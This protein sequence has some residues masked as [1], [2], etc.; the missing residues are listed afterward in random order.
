MDFDLVKFQCDHKCTDAKLHT[1]LTF[2]EGQQQKGCI[3]CVL[4]WPAFSWAT[5][6]M[7]GE[8]SEHDSCNEYALRS[9]N[10]QCG[11]KQVKVSQGV[12]QPWCTEYTIWMNSIQDSQLVQGPDKCQ[13]ITYL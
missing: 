13:N 2:P 1:N 10:L 3:Q 5:D 8:Q 7:V 9:C 12:G 6:G 4:Q 11:N